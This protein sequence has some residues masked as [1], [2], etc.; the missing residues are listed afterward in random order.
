MQVLA[1]GLTRLRVLHEEVER[2][3]AVGDLRRPVGTAGDAEQRSLDPSTAIGV[4]F[5]I[6]GGQYVAQVPEQAL[7]P[8][9]SFSNR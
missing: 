4:P 8:R 9:L 6:S 1:P 7:R 2:V 3:A 5:V